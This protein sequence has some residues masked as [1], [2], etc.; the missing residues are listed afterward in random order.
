MLIL[1]RLLRNKTRSQ[2]KKKRRFKNALI[3]LK[4]KRKR[5]KKKRKILNLTNLKR[6][7][8]N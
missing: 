5:R 7:L 6:R 3:R 8:L 1:T 2:I 4:V